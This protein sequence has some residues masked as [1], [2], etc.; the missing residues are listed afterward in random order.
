MAGFGCCFWCA[1]VW[2]LREALPVPARGGHSLLRVPYCSLRVLLLGLEGCCSSCILGRRWL[3]LNTLSRHAKPLGRTLSCRLICHGVLACRKHSHRRH[4]SNTGS[5]EKD[6]VGGWGGRVG[7]E[8]GGWM[9]VVGVGT[10][11]SGGRGDP[12]VGRGAVLS[13]SVWHTDVFPPATYL[14]PPPPAGVCS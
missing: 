11:G 5:L 13:L 4:H 12:G 7:R 6:E 14:L 10:L 8:G 1:C 9:C 3:C 2:L